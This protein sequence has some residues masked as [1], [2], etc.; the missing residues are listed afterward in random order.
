M[1][2]KCFG[3]APIALDIVSSWSAFQ[4]FERL[5]I[6]KRSYYP[7]ADLMNVLLATLRIPPFSVSNSESW[8]IV[9]K[10]E[11]SLASRMT[12]MFYRTPHT[13]CHV[14]ADYGYGGRL[15]QRELFI[16]ALL[17]KTI[18][19]LFDPFIIPPWFSTSCWHPNQMLWSQIGSLIG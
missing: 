7:W 18:P 16:K 17:K 6:L 9:K 15:A 2:A 5:P 11:T 3:I 14:G 1:A 10:P 12:R 13:S 8:V 4:D 19:F